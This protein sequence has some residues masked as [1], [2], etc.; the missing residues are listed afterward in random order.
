[1]LFIFYIINNIKERPL[2]ISEG[3]AI[4]HAYLGVNFY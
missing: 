4:Y 1:M 2:K 3:S